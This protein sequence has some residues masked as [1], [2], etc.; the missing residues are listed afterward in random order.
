MRGGPRSI[1]REGVINNKI[2]GNCMVT[3][4]CMGQANLPPYAAFVHL[5]V[6]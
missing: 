1:V 5:L 4:V 3:R 2:T 6:N